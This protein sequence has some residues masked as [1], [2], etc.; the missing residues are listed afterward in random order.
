MHYVRKGMGFD[1]STDIIIETD[2]AHGGS[3]I[4]YASLLELLDKGK[5][6]GIDIKIR[7]YNRKVIKIH[8]MF[9]RIEL[10]EGSSVYDET[11]EKIRKMVPKDSKVIVCLDSNHTKN[12]VFKELQL[13]SSFV[14]PGSYIVVFDTN[15]SKLAEL[16][17]CDK[18]YINNSPKEAVEYFLKV[19]NN[20]EIDK[21]Y[22]RLYISYSPNGYLKRIK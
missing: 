4:Y 9:K 10:I 6:I 18:M 22:N 14:N 12:H 5:V 13:Y 20:F 17:V 3:L 15:T 11:I 2:V 7:E 1:N 21:Y 19:N 16:G 8:P